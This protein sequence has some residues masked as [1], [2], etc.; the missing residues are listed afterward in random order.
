MKS[1]KTQGN[2]GMKEN[3]LKH[4]SR[5]T[6]ETHTEKKTGNEKCRLSHKVRVK[7][8]QQSKDMER[9]S[10][11][12]AKAEEMET[13]SKE[14]FKTKIRHKTSRKSGTL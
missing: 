14:M 2:R 13:Q 6:K 5:I 8:H 10:H 11:A 4:E 9:E 12:D 1:V 3:S 7:P